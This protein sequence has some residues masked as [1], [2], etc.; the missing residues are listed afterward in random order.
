MNDDE[1]Y[2][3]DLNGF[4]VLRGVLSAE[5]VATMNAAIDHHNADLNERDGSLVGESK[6]LAGTS[7]RKDLGGMLGWERPWCEPFRH[8]LIHPVVKPY[9]EAIL[10]KG[11][12]LDHGPGLIAM[13]KG[14]E[15]GTLHGGGYERSDMSEVYFYK[16]GRIHTG[17]TVVEYLLADENP[18]DGGVAVLPGSHKANLPCPRSMILWEQ[19]QEH[20]VEV[21][22]KAGDVVIFTETLT[23]GTL[24]WTADH[25][26]RALLYK[27]SPGCM[28]YSPGAHDIGYSGYIGDM[29]D[30]ERAVMEAPH[31][32]SR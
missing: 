11:Y 21:N 29:T 24:P 9:L 13:D 14:C 28:A 31:A 26:R 4:L 23:H 32:R 8:L 17:L 19:Y 16:A 22:G 15:G 3:F 27:F 10:S 30:E 7:Y 2:L 5:E 20:V 25:E 1:R 6:A 18:G 12:R